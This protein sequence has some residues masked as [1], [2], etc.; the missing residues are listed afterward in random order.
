MTEP[1]KILLPFSGIYP[2]Q[3]L[4]AKTGKQLI[5]P[6]YHAATDHPPSHLK[7]LYRL[8]SKKEFITDIDLILKYFNPVSPEILKNKED[9]ENLNKPSFILS[10]DDG[11][12]EIKDVIAPVLRQKGIP[13][14]IFLNNSFIGNKDLFY[15]Y[16]ISVIL[17][18]FKYK[19]LNSGIKRKLE[20]EFKI[21]ITSF[22][23]MQ[24]ALLKLKFTDT[25]Y[26]DRLA[27]EF[28]IDFNSYLSENKPY[29]TDLEVEEIKSQGFFIGAHSFNHPD[30]SAISETNQIKE[31]LESSEDIKKRFALDYSF[32][33][34]PF[35]DIGVSKST[36]ESL[37]SNPN[38]PDASFG[39]SGLKKELGFCHFQRIP[40]EKSSANAQSI[41]KTEYFYYFLKSLFNNN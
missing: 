8:K 15:R 21:R 11:L 3:K 41:L 7:N 33:A 20:E 30:F 6:F 4:I 35:S 27:E 1:R 31:V 2:L 39:T 32:F 9:F 22:M 25:N 38:G 28:N 26:I 16:K 17:E 29:L 24:K 10:F 36:L 13:A 23:D 18:Y 12:R 14:I 19:P 5:F 40:M 34:F 37:H